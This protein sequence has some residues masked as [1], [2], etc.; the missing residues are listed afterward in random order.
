MC[1]QNDT[2]PFSQ[3]EIAKIKLPCLYLYGAVQPVPLYHIHPI[4]NSTLRMH[5]FV[6]VELKISGF[7]ENLYS[8][9]FLHYK[10]ES[11]NKLLIGLLHPP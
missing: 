3:W 7:T 1:A 8:K 5:V 9:A 11:G 10:D 2:I 4:F 6:S